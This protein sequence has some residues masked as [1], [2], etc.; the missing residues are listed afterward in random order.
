MLKSVTLLNSLSSSAF[1]T[2]LGF[3]TMSISDS[4]SPSVDSSSVLEEGAKT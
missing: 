1:A 4:K 2:A 3:A